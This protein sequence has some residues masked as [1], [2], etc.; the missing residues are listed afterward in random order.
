MGF[1]I[2]YLSLIILTPLAALFLKA[3]RLGGGGVVGDS[4]HA[5]SDRG[6]QADLRGKRGG[7][8]G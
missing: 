6:S 3:A 5:A 4:D 2:T 1:T 7:G 8:D